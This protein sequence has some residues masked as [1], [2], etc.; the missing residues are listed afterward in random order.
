MGCQVLSPQKPLFVQKVQ[1][2]PEQHMLLQPWFDGKKMQQFPYIVNHLSDFLV[3]HGIVKAKEE[4][5][6]ASSDKNANVLSPQ[7]CHNFAHGMQT[8]E[9]MIMN[10]KYSCLRFDFQVLLDSNGVIHYIDLDRC[11][12]TGMEFRGHFWYIYAV[13]RAF[14][15]TFEALNVSCDFELTHSPD[16]SPV[17]TE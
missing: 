12:E 14:R 2:V 7:F 3:K 16:K 1:V 15:R 10:P 17:A 11:W 13:D 9:Q 5:E 6:G 4:A 8:L